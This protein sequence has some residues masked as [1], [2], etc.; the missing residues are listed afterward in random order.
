MTI[1]CAPDWQP[2]LLTDN[3]LRSVMLR[4]AK[5]AAKPTISG[6]NDLAYA[7]LGRRL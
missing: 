4:A 7:N 1:G 5:P 2:S 3:R 6:N